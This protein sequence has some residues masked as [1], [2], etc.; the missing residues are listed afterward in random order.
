MPQAGSDK[1]EESSESTNSTARAE[2]STELPTND[3]PSRTY[4][5]LFNAV[6][7][8]VIIK[9]EK[10]SALQS[11]PSS[12]TQTGS[13]AANLNLDKKHNTSQECHEYNEEEAKIETSATTA[14]DPELVSLVTG[15]ETSAIKDRKFESITNTPSQ[16]STLPGDSA[17]SAPSASCSTAPNLKATSK[18]G[19]SPSPGERC[20]KYDPPNPTATEDRPGL[21][22]RTASDTKPTYW[23]EVNAPSISTQSHLYR[24]TL[25]GLWKKAVGMDPKLVT[26]N[27][28]ILPAVGSSSRGTVVSDDDREITNPG[29]LVPPYDQ[30]Q[31]RRE[32]KS[33]SDVLTGGDNAMTSKVG[34]GKDMKGT[35]QPR[36]R[37]DRTLHVKDKPSKIPQHVHELYPEL[38]GSSREMPR[39]ERWSRDGSNVQKGGLMPAVRAVVKETDTDIS[40]PGGTVS[41]NDQSQRRRESKSDSVALTGGKKLNPS[42]AGSCLEEEDSP[43]NSSGLDGTS[44]PDNNQTR[45]IQHVNTLSPELFSDNRTLP[46][47][48]T[49]RSDHS[50]ICKGRIMPAVA[51]VAHED[52]KDRSNSG[53]TVPANDPAQ[54]EK[55]Q[56]R[57]ASDFIGRRQ[58][59]SSKATSAVDSDEST[60]NRMIR[61]DTVNINDENPG[62]TPRVDSLSPGLCSSSRASYGEVQRNRDHFNIRK[63]GI[64][65]VVTT[66]I[67]D[68]AIRSSNAG[69][70]VPSKGQ[71]PETKCSK[72]SLGVVKGREQ[73]ESWKEPAVDAGGSSQ[74]RVVRDEAIDVD[75]RNPKRTPHY[76]IRGPGLPTHESKIPRAMPGRRKDL[77]IPKRMQLPTVSKAAAKEPRP[78]VSFHPQLSTTTH[79]GSSSIP[80]AAE[81][82]VPAKANDENPQDAGSTDGN[83]AFQ[84]RDPSELRQ[85]ILA[86]RK[87]Y[88]LKQH[89]WNRKMEKHIEEIDKKA[90]ELVEINEMVKHQIQY[91]RKKLGLPSVPE[92]RWMT[93]KDAEG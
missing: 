31:G 51:T 20:P 40:S 55:E 58:P 29:F 88:P 66:V 7:S 15:T 5:D 91:L 6:S 81:N 56:I 54:G 36:I 25:K 2:T 53:F 28:V 50:N 76:N 69:V 85:H 17:N 67:Q 48:A 21:H 10:Q 60:Q 33:D 78:K 52:V 24:P 62:N 57:N 34:S 87:K 84:S 26:Q 38:C 93:K 70:T 41:S 77:N 74:S 27:L 49:R 16:R 14:A 59:Q 12:S 47:T 64:M 63:G 71:S 83:T 42:K 73:V 75:D 43:Q 72:G 18:F 4:I 11:N 23:R 39:A 9:T 37:P 1:E 22:P 8:A 46:R 90:V 35:S 61:D 65:P 89:E 30:S 13:G 19:M 92:H 45:I 82:N 80:P 3:T 68:D 86:H 32:S 44:N 79:K